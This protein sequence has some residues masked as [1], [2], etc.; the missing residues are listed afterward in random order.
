MIR[1]VHSSTFYLVSRVLFCSALLGVLLRASSI[2]LEI[3][4][5]LRTVSSSSENTSTIVMTGSSFLPISALNRLALVMMIS[6]LFAWGT[7]VWNIMDRF[8]RSDLVQLENVHVLAKYDERNYC[9]SVQTRPGNGVWKPFKENLCDD[10]LPHAVSGSTL[11]E[12]YFIPDFNMKCA[13]WRNHRQ[14]AGMVVLEDTKTNA[15]ILTPFAEY[16]TT[17]IETCSA[18]PSADAGTETRAGR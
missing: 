16:S 18:R 5:L 11:T 4:K 3:P 13:D 7:T 15:P 10:A 6:T 8:H 9:M 2:F 1:W 14:G 12:F 17:S